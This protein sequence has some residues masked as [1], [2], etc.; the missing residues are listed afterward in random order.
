[1]KV[2][3]EPPTMADFRAAVAANLRRIEE[4]NRDPEVQATLAGARAEAAAAARMLRERFGARRVRLFGS[5][6]RGDADETFDVDLAVEGVEPA[7]FFE[8]WAVAAGLVRRKLDLVDLAD[9][10]PLLRSRIEEDGVD[11]P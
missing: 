5:L 1:M 10:P 4:R 8:A 3:Y 11:L 6:A 7:R 2:P 9:A